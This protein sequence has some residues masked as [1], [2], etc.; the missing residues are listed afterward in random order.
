MLFNLQNVPGFDECVE[1]LKAGDIEATLAELDLGRFLFLHSVSF[2]YVKPISKKGSDYDVDITYPNGVVASADAKCK[3]DGE[4]NKKTIENS[5]ETARKQ[6]PKDNPGIVFVKHPASW[7]KEHFEEMRELT[8]KFFSRTERIVSV[9]YYVQPFERRGDNLV[10]QHG[11]VEF[12]NPKTRFG[13]NI[14][15]DL[16]PV[17]VLENFKLPA[18]WQRI[19]HYGGKDID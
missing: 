2:R 10:H 5:L 7:A 4:F 15:W 16:F 6:L 14:D 18:H 1:R 11:Y 9:K 3:V 17:G 12:S 8:A 19:L 13:N